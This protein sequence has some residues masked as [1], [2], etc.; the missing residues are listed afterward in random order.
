M[1]FVIRQKYLMKTF[2]INISKMSLIFKYA[3]MVEILFPFTCLKQYCGRYIFVINTVLVSSKESFFHH[4]KLLGWQKLIICNISN[5]IAYCDNCFACRTFKIS[6]KEKRHS[7]GYPKLHI[8]IYYDIYIRSKEAEEDF[9]W[10]IY[11]SHGQ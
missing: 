2:N 10:Q 8:L 7:P 9:L 3:K 1:L 11:M 6:K 5:S 4:P